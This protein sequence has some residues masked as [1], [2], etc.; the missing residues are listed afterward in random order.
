M[1][2]W[3]LSRDTGISEYLLTSYLIWH[4]SRW[5]VMV[6]HGSFAAR[7]KLENSS[8]VTMFPLLS[9]FFLL[10]CLFLCLFACWFFSFSPYLQMFRRKRPRATSC[11][12]T[13]PKPSTLCGRRQDGTGDL[14]FSSQACSILSHLY[15]IYIYM[16]IYIYIYVQYTYIIYV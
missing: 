13:R 14:I 1:L 8:N 9:F 15:N 11:L 12:K 7:K 3:N 10:F 5:K 6:V 16:V 4:M 2:D